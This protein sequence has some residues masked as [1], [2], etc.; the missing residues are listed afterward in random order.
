V[1]DHAII[2]PVNSDWITDGVQARVHGYHRDAQDNQRF[3][4]AWLSE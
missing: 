4:D 2:A 3:N 1:L